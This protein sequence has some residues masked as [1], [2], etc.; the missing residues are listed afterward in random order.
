MRFIQMKKHYLNQI[1]KNEDF[2][3]IYISLKIQQQCFLN[4]FMN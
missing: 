3:G 4:H 1:W 2:R